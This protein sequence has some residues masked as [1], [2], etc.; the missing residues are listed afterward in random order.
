M[1]DAIE[2]LAAVLLED[3]RSPLYDGYAYT[4]AEIAIA[5]IQADPLA[6]V[7]PK[8]LEWWEPCSANNQTIGSKTPFGTY[9]IHIDGGRHQAWVDNVVD[10]DGSMV[11]DE[12]GDMFTAQAAAYDDLCKRVKELF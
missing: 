4:V 5:A 11:G 6:Y 3:E 2:K 10:G 8:P 9:Y 7:K 12:C 1:T